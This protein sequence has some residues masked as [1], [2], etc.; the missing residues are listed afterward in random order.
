MRVR[1]PGSWLRRTGSGLLCACASLLVGTAAHAAAGGRLPDAGALLAVFGV[2]TVLGTALAGPRRR[3]DAAVL[4]LG[5]VQFALHIVFP[6]LS[7]RPLSPASPASP[8]PHS[9]HAGAGTFPGARGIPHG[10]VPSGGP[11]AGTDS[12]QGALGSGLA[13]ADAAGHSLTTAMTAGHALAT[14]GT[15]LCL[16]FGERLLRR[17]RALLW[18]GLRHHCAESF[19]LPAHPA[20]PVPAADEHRLRTGALTRCHPRRGP[21][22]LA[23]A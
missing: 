12:P 22:L 11:A 19:P 18:S 16:V 7:S 17:L 13:S 4:S 2:L 6:L 9:R 23:P 20:S 3:F 8:A 15:A 1:G 14:L 10:P 21:P 5:A